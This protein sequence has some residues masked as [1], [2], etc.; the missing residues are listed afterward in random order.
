[1]SLALEGIGVVVCF[2]DPTGFRKSWSGQGAFNPLTEKDL[3]LAMSLTQ[4]SFGFPVPLFVIE[5]R[6]D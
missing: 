3:V 6:Q 4:S 5:R 1:M 2:I